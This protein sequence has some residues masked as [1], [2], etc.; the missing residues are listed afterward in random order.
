MDVR[1]RQALSMAINREGIRRQIMEG[2]CLPTGQAMPE[3]AMGY[4]PSIKAP[5]Y[6]ADGARRSCWPRPAI[7]DG[8]AITL[9]GPNDRYVNDDSI[10]QAMAQMWTPHRREDRRRRPARPAS[11]SPPAACGTNT[12]SR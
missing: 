5:A 4:D 10:A 9:H 12:P 2:F 3:G 8:F 11:S 7:P 1:V 6:D